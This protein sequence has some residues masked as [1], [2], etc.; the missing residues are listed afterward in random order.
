MER[1]RKLLATAAV[2]L[3]ETFGFVFAAIITKTVDA[4]MLT[5][6]YI[7]VAAALA[8]YTGGNVVSKFSSGPVDK[9]PT[10]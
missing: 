6:F 7:A 10:P 2:L 5:A 9:P 4:G 1:L 3:L 8:I